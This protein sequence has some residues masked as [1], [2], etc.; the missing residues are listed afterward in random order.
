MSKSLRVGIVGGGIGGVALARSLRLSGIDAYVFERANAFGEIGAGV[1]MTPNAAKVLRALGLGEELARIGFL[2]N[3]MVGRNWDDARELFHT[4]LREVCPKLFGADFWHVH[5]ADLHAILC[6]G[7]PADRVRF[8][9]SCT[10]ITQLKDK[11]VAHFS[12]GTQFEADLIVGADGIHSVVRDSLWGKTPSQYTGHMCWRAVV[13]VEQHPLPFVTPDA[14]FW[15]GPKAHI[16]TYYVKGGA[17]VNIVAVNESANWV[18]ESWTEP[19]TREE[20]L[21]AFEGW[22]D[23]IIHLFEKTDAQQIF[24][25]GLF[26]RDP[27]TQWSKG[28]V[29]LLGDAA[30]PMLPFLSQGAAMAIEDA[31]V[32]AT[33]ISH[34]S[35][36]LNEALN[37][38][39]AERRPRTARVQLEARE[40]GRTYHLS[41]PEEKRKRDEDF[42]NAQTKDPNAVGIKAEWVYSYDATACVE[43]FN[44][45]TKVATA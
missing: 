38:Y 2:P 1:Q 27:M 41:T 43:R 44:E 6:Q 26:D 32:L 5:R 13:P 36:D 12:D 11:A 30:H 37:A 22:H 8:N 42:Q 40:R 16:V 25:W 35:G 31:Y 23:N 21:A 29:T 4:P 3:A 17:A 20:L 33:A 7:I 34:F 39:E 24:K 19:S 9:V 15:M 45:N 14:S 28:N 10:G 18:T